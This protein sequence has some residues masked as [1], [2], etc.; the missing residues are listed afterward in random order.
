MRPIEVAFRQ[1]A[2]SA[3]QQMGLSQRQVAKRMEA[4][5]HG[6]HQTTLSRIEKGER[7]V[8]LGEAADLADVFGVRL[9]DLIGDCPVDV[10]P[11]VQD[12]RLQGFRECADRVHRALEFGEQELRALS[13][14]GGGGRG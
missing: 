9:A 3:R 5:G 1:N 7:G 8:S 2:I 14:A 12:A 11:A 6:W 13:H 4:H 10:P